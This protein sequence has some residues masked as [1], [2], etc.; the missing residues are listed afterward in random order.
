MAYPTELLVPEN[1]FARPAATVVKQPHRFHVIGLVHLPVSEEYM[2]C[3]FTQKIVKMCRMLMS[4][5]HEVILYGCEGSDAPCTE[6]VQTHTLSDIRQ[7]WGDGDNR[8]AIGYDWQSEQ[9]RHDINQLRTPL[10]SRF[11]QT[12]IEELGK[13]AKLTDFLLIMQGWYQKPISDAIKLPLTVEPG[14][15]YRGSYAQWRAF[16]SSYIYHFMIG[17]VHESRDPDGAYYWRIIPNYWD[18]KDFPYNLGKRDDYYLYVGRL[19]KRKGLWTAIQ[20]VKAVGGKLLVAGQQSNEIRA[21]DLPPWVEYVGYVGAEERAKLMGNARALF[22]PTYYLEPF[23]GVAVEAMLT[24][25]P[26]ITTNFGAFIDTVNHGVTGYR[27]DTLQDFVT[28]ARRVEELQPDAVRRWAERYLTINVR[29]EF[30]KYWQ[31][32]WQWWLS[33]YD[34]QFKNLGWN[35]IEPE[36]AQNGQVK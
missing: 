10:Y 27:C 8:F 20:T 18:Q 6:F 13:R 7:T 28:A 11:N 36:P 22:V 33:A 4:L 12:V 1:E 31:D 24:G 35:Y 29:W 3:A 32:L 26:V 15:G 25:T 30:Q 19:I 9:F 21:N 14:I 2:A 23:G 5:G 17:K 34:P 16:E